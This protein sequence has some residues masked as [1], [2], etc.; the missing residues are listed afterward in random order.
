MSL[1]ISTVPLPARPFNPTALVALIWLCTLV[2][3]FVDL[4]LAQSDLRGAL[5]AFAEYAARYARP[6]LSELP[7]ALALMGQTLAM[8]LWGTAL[9]FALGAVLAPLAAAALTP[10]AIC[11]RLV[12]ELLN[13]LRA[14][15]DL[16]LALL[17][18]TAFGLG[19]LPGLIALGLH[20][21]GFLGK[22]LAESMERVDRGIYEGVRATGAGSVQLIMFA[23]WPM[24][25]REAIG[26]TLYIFDRNVRMATVLGLVGAGGIGKAIYDLI[27][28]FEFSRAS[29]MLLVMITTIIAIDYGTTWL[30]NKLY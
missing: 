3:A 30:R 26:Y 16:L 21:A 6:D 13:L 1:N 18:V 29:G 7:T 22:F 19:P 11:Y 20:T 23:A 27:R 10:N 24:I 28:I 8:A 5:A 25:L 14:L 9:A 4:E 15:P 17:L 2:W 12:R